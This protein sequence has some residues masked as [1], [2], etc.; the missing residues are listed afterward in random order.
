MAIKRTKKIKV[1]SGKGLGDTIEQIT[2]KTGI[3]KVVELFV[4][5]EDCGCDERKKKLNKL[6]SYKLKARC[7]TEV[8]YNEWVELKSNIGLPL[9]KEQKTYIINKY[10]SVFNVPVY[11]PQENNDT[12]PLLRMIDNIDKVYEVY[13]EELKV[14]KTTI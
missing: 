3:K 5:G 4:N 6:F 1:D 9:K 2:T 11:I 7:L 13:K 12:K 10:A 8:E 14:L